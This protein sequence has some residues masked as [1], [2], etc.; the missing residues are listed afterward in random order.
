MVPRN[1]ASVVL[2]TLM[3]APS[4]AYA[5][6]PFGGLP[7][8]A[9][10]RAKPPTLGSPPPHSRSRGDEP[11]SPRDDEPS[12]PPANEVH[13]AGGAERA[14]AVNEA[15]PRWHIT[16]AIG[17]FGKENGGGFMLD[18]LVLRRIGPVGIGVNLDAALEGLFGSSSAVAAVAVGVFADTPRSIDLG[19]VATL[20]VRSA[21]V[22]DEGLFADDPGRSGTT[23]MFSVRT[24]TAACFGRKSRRFSLGPSVFVDDD[25]AR[26]KTG[27]YTYSSTGLFGGRFATTTSH[28]IGAFRYGAV[29]ALGSTF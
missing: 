28:T 23:G 6:E 5:D 9:E 7:P 29:L 17:G 24:V 22:A 3:I 26:I 19:L 20:G 16:G 1:A 11:S 27:T 15:R 8:L 13:W 14:D 21:T 10:P 12:S 18:F 25:L 2:L 4:L